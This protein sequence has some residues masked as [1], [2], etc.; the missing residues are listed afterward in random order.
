MACA[1][2]Q[3]AASYGI[4]SHNETLARLNTNAH[5]LAHLRTQ[6]KQLPLQL[7]RLEGGGANK[8]GD[9]RGRCCSPGSRSFRALV[10]G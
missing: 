9:L 2:V 1:M 10:G 6:A 8:E 4:G 7:G 5:T 3:L